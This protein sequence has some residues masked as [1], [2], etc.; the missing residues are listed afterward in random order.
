MG[1]LTPNPLSID[2]RHVYGMIEML[3]D[4]DAPS[5]PG[6]M[7][8]EEPVTLRSFIDT[9]SREQMDAWEAWARD[10]AD[11]LAVSTRALELALLDSDAQ[12]LAAQEVAM[13]VAWPGHP[14]PRGSIPWMYFD[15]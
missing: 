2:C 12:A 9:I 15:D 14:P 5:Q 7:D 10:V 13:Q 11:S 4:A 6:Y 8:V 1:L 3:M